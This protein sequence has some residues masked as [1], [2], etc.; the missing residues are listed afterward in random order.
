MIFALTTLSLAQ[1]INGCANKNNGI[2]RIVSNASQCTAAE[3]FISWNQ[4][5]PAGV[6]SAQAITLPPGSQATATLNSGVLTIGVPQGQTGATGAAGAAGA[7]GHSPVLTW[8]GDQ[9]AID[10]VVT[11]PHL[12]GPAGVANGVS[13]IIYGAVNLTHDASQPA[14]QGWGWEPYGTGFTVH[15][16]AQSSANNGVAL[17]QFDDTSWLGATCFAATWWPNHDGIIAKCGY[18]GRAC[19]ETHTPLVDTEWWGI[20]YDQGTGIGRACLWVHSYMTNH[21][22]EWDGYIGNNVLTWD[23]IE[24]PNAF[25]F[26]CFQ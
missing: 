24:A 18:Y 6:T 9:I 2:L 12:T 14:P 16:T 13:R 21:T 4:V 23:S 5:G 26:V 7:A 17:V 1:T 25:T 8:S 10:N 11:G 22:Y 19:Y 20:C 3:N 15:N